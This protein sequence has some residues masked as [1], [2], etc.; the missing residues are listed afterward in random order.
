V[1]GGRK[2]GSWIDD[3]VAWLV[4]SGRMVAWLTVSGLLL[5]PLMAALALAAYLANGPGSIPS[6]GDGSLMTGFV[7]GL[8]LA[9]ILGLVGLTLM[10]PARANPYEYRD[11]TIR[12]GQLEDEFTKL[13]LKCSAPDSATMFADRGLRWAAGH[14]YL[15]LWTQIHAA[16]EALFMV[17]DIGWLAAEADRDLQRLKGSNMPQ[18]EAFTTSI[19]NAVK[20]LYPEAQQQYL[21]GAVSGSP[22]AVEAA[23]WDS[24]ARMKLRDARSG[25]NAYR[26]SIWDGL[27]RA[28]NQFLRSLIAT[29]LITAILVDFI[30][31]RGTDHLM[32]LVAT[33]LYLVGVLVGLFGRLQGL[34]GSASVEEDFGLDTSHLLA[35]PILSGIAAVVGVALVGLL[36]L[37][38]GD[39]NIGAPSVG[40]GESALPPVFNL[41]RN[42]G[43][44]IIAGLFGLTPELLIRYLKSQADTFSKGLSTTETW[45][46][47]SPATV[48]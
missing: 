45:G 28:R 41:G 29:T 23:R 39:I 47:S 38:I 19:T 3:L 32:L 34:V 15:T 4:P 13:K 48:P 5:P 17:E 25:I 35:V 1:G 11:L 6:G 36:K 10:T 40:A 18:A 2:P 44:L 12:R 26:Q 21:G 42:P 27:V 30:V 37:K 9:I 31:L 8:L 22:F 7:L 16:E 33:V 24:L 43:A 46:K 20:A 14:G